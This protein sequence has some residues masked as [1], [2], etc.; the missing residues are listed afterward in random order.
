MKL[1]EFPLLT[2]ENVDPDVVAHLRAVGFDVL[3]VIECRWQGA[4]DV[5]LLRRA[6]GQGRVVMTHDADFGTLAVLQHEPLVGIVYLR[7]NHIDP[8][9]TVATIQ[10]VLNAD[11]DL[12][13]PFVL[14]AKRT[15]KRVTIRVRALG[16]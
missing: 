15:G 3:D 12:V 10:T 14:V 16:P 7:P 2:D 13:P 8:R 11:P 9:F 1:R 4:A 6:T 5:D